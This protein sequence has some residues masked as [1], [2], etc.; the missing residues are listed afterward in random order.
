VN[1]PPKFKADPTRAHHAAVQVDTQADSTASTP[2]APSQRQA[3]RMDVWS[4][5]HAGMLDPVRQTALNF[6]FASRSPR[7]PA[8]FNN[9]RGEGRK[10]GPN[11]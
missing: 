2:Y 5:R 1:R 7:T 10:I 4:Y 9:T 11:K 8:Q 6:A 3:T